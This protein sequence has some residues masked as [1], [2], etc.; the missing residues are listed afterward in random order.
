MDLKPLIKMEIL[1]LNQE[2]IFN[3]FIKEKIETYDVKRLSQSNTIFKIKPQNFALCKKIIESNQIKL[4]STKSIGLYRLYKNFLLRIGIAISIFVCLVMC[5]IANMFILR[6]E[7]MGNEIIEDNQIIE[8]LSTKKIGTFTNKS[9]INVEELELDL[10]QNFS[11]ISM[12]SIIEKGSTLIINIKEKS[13][14]DE[15][16]T[17]DYENLVSN[18]NGRITEFQL[19]SG[20]PLKNVGD[21]V[22]VGDILV[23]SSYIDSSGNTQKIKAQAN[24]SAEVWYESRVTH[25]DSV[26]RTQATGAETQF[27]EISLM[28]LTIFSNKQENKYQKF[29][30]T[31]TEKSF[32]NS[33]LPLKITYYK[34]V[35]MASIEIVTDFNSVK[36]ELVSNCKQNALQQVEQN[37]III[38][39]NCTITEE[40]GYTKICYLVTVN[41]IIS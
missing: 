37:D 14:N 38:N 10:M 3:K 34:Y 9:T 39:E 5:F 18:F 30:E 6:I 16:V 28:G 4:A 32:V 7:V 24:I 11:K 40:L 15:Y 29:E 21:I 2:K 35:E 19:V 23:Q 1:G 22:K 8:F 27:Y 26:I 25:Y 12:I 20:T 41:K 17:G 33:I 13:T 36:D 31:I